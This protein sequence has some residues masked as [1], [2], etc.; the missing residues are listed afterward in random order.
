MTNKKT[1][2]HGCTGEQ[3]DAVAKLMADVGKAMRTEYCRP[4]GSPTYFNNEALIRNFG[5]EPGVKEV[6]GERAADVREALKAELDEGRPVLYSGYPVEGDGHALVC[7][8]YTANYYFH[9][10]RIYNYSIIMTAITKGKL[11]PY[12][13]ILKA[14]LICI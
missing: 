1:D 9:F 12:H 6:R 8:G 13:S 4:N 2:L 3:A 10:T 5:Y 11:I 14:F 7:D